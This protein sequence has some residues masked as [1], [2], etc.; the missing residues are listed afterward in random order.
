MKKL[1]LLQTVLDVFWFS[2]IIAVIAIVL[3][4]GYTL[5]NGPINIPINV[6]G[7]PHSMVSLTSKVILFFIVVAYFIFV[8]GIYNLR[9][10]LVLFS[11]KMIFEE[12]TIAL[13]NKVGKS[14]L[15]S[16]LIIF[17]PLFFYNVIE[18]GETKIEFG[19]GFSSF[20]F[21]SSLGLF[22]MVL[23]EVFKVAKTLKDEND[24]TV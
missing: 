18:R 17:V 15:F 22:F 23:S 8:F 1:R 2:S 9:K 3:F 20:L 24:L 14:F 7:E 5:V 4:L 21:A 16:S 10:V 19:G 6:N 12:D 11:N 13:L